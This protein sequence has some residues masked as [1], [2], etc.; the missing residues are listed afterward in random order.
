M[1]FCRHHILGN[2]TFSWWGAWLGKKDGQ[3]VYAPRRYWQNIDR[4]NPDLYP[5]KW[6]L[7]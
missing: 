3:I 4:P 2:S 7:I 6:R 1:S 5:E